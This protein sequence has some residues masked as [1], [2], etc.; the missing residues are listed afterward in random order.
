M[1]VQSFVGNIIL[2]PN[3]P[4]QICQQTAAHLAPRVWGGKQGWAAC[5]KRV[6]CK[7]QAAVQAASCNEMEVA[8]AGWVHAAKQL[9]AL[10]SLKT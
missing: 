9:G 2:D 7:V 8:L 3:G 1:S 10:L 4:L 5:N 6:S